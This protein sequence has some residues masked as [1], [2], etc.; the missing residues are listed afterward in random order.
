MYL[1]VSF[2]WTLI[3]AFVINLISGE[4]SIRAK[5]PVNPV[6]EG[7]VF[8]LY[9]EVRNLRSN[10]EVTLLR[11][12]GG[13][14]ET[15]S[16][17]KDI[18]NSVDE[19]IFLSVKQMKDGYVI[20]FLTIAEVTRQDEGEY[21][22]RVT[23]RESAMLVTVASTELN[24][25]FFPSDIDPRCSS[26]IPGNSLTVREGQTV[27]F[28][29]T[30]EMAFPKVSL[31]WS[32]ATTNLESTSVSTDHGRVY[33]ILRIRARR[34]HDRVIFL[35]RLTSSV[36]PDK[37]STCHVG[38]IHVIPDPTFDDSSLPHTAFP[39]KKT[40]VVTKQDVKIHPPQTSN[41]KE[42]CREFCPSAS[43]KSFFW[44]VSTII[45][46]LLAVAF[47]IIGMILFVKYCRLPTSGNMD[48]HPVRQSSDKLYA[49]LECRQTVAPR[50]LYMTTEKRRE[51]Y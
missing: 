2:L 19:R 27:S 49:E 41:S 32:Y 17:D 38:P 30:S 35:C 14:M 4:P 44:I 9:C 11:K 50:Q 25:M 7:G 23:N 20:Y 1:N 29:C 37:Q 46:A 39:P 51:E 12:I 26:D 15:L 3:F 5:T 36:F 22:C 10:D 13:Y 48:F 16:V 45:S 33:A 34:S 42:N 24:V 28:N 31:K 47:F 40:P 8:S 6:Q 43:S 21:S 18:L